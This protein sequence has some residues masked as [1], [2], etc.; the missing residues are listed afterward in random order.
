MT[1]ARRTGQ[2]CVR[3]T[4][5]TMVP[6]QIQGINNY[7]FLEARDLLRVTTPTRPTWNHGEYEAFVSGSR[8]VPST[9]I[10]TSAK[11]IFVPVSDRF[12]SKKLRHKLKMLR[13]LLQRRK[14]AGHEKAWPPFVVSP[15][16][17][18]ASEPFAWRILFWHHVWK[19]YTGY[20]H[21]TIFL[22]I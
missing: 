4:D 21:I 15:S 5:Q 16:C 7:L 14:W 13:R 2:Q 20:T 1:I 12:G 6:A 11:H 8:L 9:W 19:G 22:E 18:R 10:K 17:P 3:D